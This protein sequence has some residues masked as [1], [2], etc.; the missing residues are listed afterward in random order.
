MQSHCFGPTRRLVPGFLF[1]IAVSAGCVV[2]GCSSL[3]TVKPS[4]AAVPS[5]RTSPAV[6]A[7]KPAPAAVGPK[8][9]LE[10]HCEQLA[11]A[12]PGLEELRVGSNGTIE[13]RQWTLIAHDSA[14]RWVV[15]RGKNQARDGWSPRPGIGKLNFNPPI[16][17]ALAKGA[18]RFLAYAPSDVKNYS[19]LET[20]AT[21]NEV[22]GAPQGKFQWRGRTYGYAL[23]NE[24]PCY[25]P[26]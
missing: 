12:V 25:P 15:V 17:P 8:E 9:E 7:A 22:F 23:A 3:W 5:S 13:S 24:L 14:P 19:D 20:M 11:Q 18:S 4:P 6:S 1:A 26:Q 2:G 16:A 10:V 21:L